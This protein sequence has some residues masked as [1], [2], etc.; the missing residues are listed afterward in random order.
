MKHLIQD[1]LKGKNLKD[2]LKRYKN[3]AVS[4]YSE[5]AA[6]ELTF[7]AYVM[8][9]EIVEENQ[10]LAAQEKDIVNQILEA[11]GMLGDGS[12]GTDPLIRQMKDLRREITDKMDV[13]TCYTDR[14]LVYEYVLN[15]MELTFL[16]EEELNQIF[17]AFDENRYM[18]QL[19][20]YL[21]AD[22]DQ[23]VIREKL[24]LV[25]GQIPVHMTKGKFSQRVSEALTLYKDGDRRALEDFIY[26]IRTSAMVYE[27]AKYVGEYPAFETILHRLETADYTSMEEDLY[28]ELADLLEEG[29]RQIH[30]VTD[31]YYSLQ[32]VVNC[33]YALCLM[34]PYQEKESRLVRGCRQVWVSLA[35]KDY[36]DEMLEPLEG[37]IEDRLERTSYLETV[38]FDSRDSYRAELEALEL[39]GFFEDAATV[40]N[41]LSDSLFID[42]ASASREEKADAAYVQKRTREL[43]DELMQKLGELSRPVKRA[44]MGQVLDKLPLMFEK[45]EEVLEYI[46]VNLMGC[47][48]KAEKCVVMMILQDL[49]DE[50]I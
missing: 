29:A 4:A 32:K 28:H 46:Q 45:A 37:Q 8:V 24:R 13:F 19:S 18:Q 15:R 20:G 43:L 21:F 12:A 34:V 11:L 7:S 36:R 5:Y 26:M 10:E 50:D 49:M 48:N 16:P 1:I 44:V 35:R 42:L 41:L 31:F 2:N 3:M 33:M 40:A 39:T 38:L 23:S 47:Q 27:P 9:Q 17:A 14:L 30:E 6:L 22:R 25:L